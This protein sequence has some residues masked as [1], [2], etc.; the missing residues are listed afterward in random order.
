MDTVIR[1]L[2]NRYTA[3][4]LGL[5]FLGFGVMVWTNDSKVDGDIYCNTKRMSAGDSCIHTDYRHPEKN[6]TNSYQEERAEQE[7]NASQ[8]DKALGILCPILAVGTIGGSIG[9]MVRASRRS[10]AKAQ[11]TVHT[12]PPGV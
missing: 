12:A 5:A 4:L 8:S 1:V 3:L 10:K 9:F 6:H 11:P 2:F 7:R